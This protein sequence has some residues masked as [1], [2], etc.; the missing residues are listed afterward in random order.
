MQKRYWLLTVLRAGESVPQRVELK[1][2]RL[3]R[4]AFS[5]Q[6][7]RHLGLLST[8]PRARR[9]TEQRGFH[10]QMVSEIRWCCTFTIVIV[11]IYS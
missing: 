10:E 5:R 1:L 9:A 8:D 4:T 3:Y 11:Y 2:A 6:Q 7:Q